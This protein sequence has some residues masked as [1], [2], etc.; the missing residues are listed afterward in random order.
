MK[1][2]IKGKSK[3]MPEPEPAP[4]PKL[5]FKSDP[6]RKQKVSAPQHWVRQQTFWH[7]YTPPTHILEF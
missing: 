6:E 4:E 2:V 5:F 7:T 3:L 1:S